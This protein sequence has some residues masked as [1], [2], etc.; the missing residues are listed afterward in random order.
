M[1]E[2]KGGPVK[3]P[4][5]DLKPARSTKKK[6]A[7]SPGMKSSGKAPKTS[8][9]SKNE[10]A[11]KN[12]NDA[13]ENN[14]GTTKAESFSTDHST[15]KSPGIAIIPL[16]IGMIGSS[17]L[18]IIILIPLILL[19]IVRPLNQPE[20]PPQLTYLEQRIGATE[21]LLTQ[22]L[23]ILNVMDDQ[24]NTLR[25]QLGS[26]MDEFSNRMTRLAEQQKD[27]QQQ[28]VDLSENIN[29]ITLQLN[30][31]QAN[32]NNG[33]KLA[34]LEKSISDLN[35]RMS[36]IAAG[37]SSEDAAKLGAEIAQI[38]EDFQKLPEIVQGQFQTILDQQI[39]DLQS[40]MQQ[41]AS[42]MD[43]LEIQ[44]AEVVATAQTN[45]Q[46]ISALDQISMDQIPSEEN[47]PNT[48]NQTMQVSLYLPLA[49]MGVETALANGR[50]F[51]TELQS[52]ALYL[53]SLEIPETLREMAR[54]N[55]PLPSA[56]I[57]SFNRTIPSILAA[58][59][60]D[61]DAGWSEQLWNNIR[62]LL[63]LRP[64]DQTIG[65][66]IEV[67]VSQI[68]SAVNR[69]DFSAAATLIS[70]L[71]QPMI[72][73]LGEL[74]SQIANLAD[75]NNLLQQARSLTLSQSTGAQDINPSE[76][77]QSIQ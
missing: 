70:Q 19:G 31:I 62:A 64:T 65:D 4:I 21:K 35:T 46:N 7:P 73:A 38:R 12:K 25:E 1:V 56:I 22:N 43:D 28:Q 30:N 59:P 13:P 50:N 71:P 45:T 40:Q 26:E 57:E 77:V 58:R 54:D 74:N 53:P 75:A 23:T 68:E 49:L 32:E 48:Q 16:A 55:R 29:N 20:V 10:T 60:K 11:E 67:L 66:P 76:P 24:I 33:E 39:M 8:S 44:L 15:Q 47:L 3:P 69:S 72:L 63:A 61:P 34:S 42:S 51:D 14:K 18:T 9:A 52:L 2:P 36:A 17:L 37:S 5:L 27:L 6:S 41:I